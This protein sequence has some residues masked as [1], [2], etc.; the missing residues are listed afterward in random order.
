MFIVVHIANF[1]AQTQQR[2]DAVMALQ[3]Q[4][5]ENAAAGVPPPQMGRYIFID[6]YL[7]NRLLYTTFMSVKMA[8][9]NLASHS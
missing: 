6:I 3:M 8:V 9:T 1:Q 2:N 5:Q 4:H 7:T